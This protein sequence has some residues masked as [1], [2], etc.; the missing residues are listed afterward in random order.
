[1]LISS[2]EYRVNVGNIQE[3]YKPIERFGIIK[4]NV[5]YLQEVDRSLIR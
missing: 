2:K 3:F 1:M 4:D 5:F